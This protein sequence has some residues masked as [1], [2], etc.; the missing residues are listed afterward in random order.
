MALDDLIDRDLDG[1]S[2]EESLCCLAFSLIEVLV[3]VY[4]VS[5][6]SFEIY[7]FNYLLVFLIYVYSSHLF[8]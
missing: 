4:K 5:L 8:S 7:F 2:N 6:I 1:G 3:F